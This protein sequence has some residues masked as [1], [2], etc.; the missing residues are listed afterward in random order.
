MTALGGIRGGVAAQSGD[1]DQVSLGESTAVKPDV[2]EFAAE[3][4]C[5]RWAGAE[6]EAGG[7]LGHAGV[8]L[9]RRRGRGQHAVHIEP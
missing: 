8:S 2:G 9:A 6:H 3:R 4:I 5:A 7:G 1:G